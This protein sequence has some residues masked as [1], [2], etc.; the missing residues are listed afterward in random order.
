MTKLMTTAGALVLLAATATA[1]NSAGAPNNS[2]GSGANITAAPSATGTSTASAPAATA[3][4]RNGE[5]EV[6]AFLDRVYAPYASGGGE[7][8]DYEAVLEP[9]LAA[10][11]GATEGGP[12]ADPFIDAQDWTAFRPTYENIQVR[13]ERATAT[14][15]FSNGGT[16]TRI[17]YELLRTPAG[18]R[19]YDI[20]SANGGSLRQQFMRAAR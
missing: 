1:C 12:G 8:A 20:Q 15:T 19:A 7:G 10:A 18:W 6:R 16:P 11:I 9:Q 3:D 2:S 17:R 4:A 5:A 14:A 13:G